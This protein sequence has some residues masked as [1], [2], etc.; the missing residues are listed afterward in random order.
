MDSE[1]TRA[2]NFGIKKSQGEFLFFIDSDMILDK[3]VIEE[4]VKKFLHDDAIASIIVPE[5]SIGSSFWVKVRDFERQMYA[6]T[7]VEAARFYRKKYV[8]MVNGFDEDIVFYEDHTL[9]HKIENLGYRTNE[10]ISS[11]IFHN[12]EGFNFSNWLKK[13]RYYA[14]TEKNYVDRYEQHVKSPLS[15]T[16]RTKIFFSNGNWKLL[17]KHPILTFGLFTL[18]GF[19]YFARKF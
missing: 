17:L 13:K 5:H 14:L 16:Y 10:R 6:N 7:S 18:K 19:E 1:R 15:I 9:P 3:N 11:Y 4:C 12:E 2:K 8:S